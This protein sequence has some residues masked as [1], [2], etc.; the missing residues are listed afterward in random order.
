ME[1]TNNTL[2]KATKRCPYCGEEIKATAKKCRHCGEWLEEE[3]QPPTVNEEP[4]AGDSEAVEEEEANQIAPPWSSGW[5]TL[6]FVLAV[7]GELL[8]LVQEDWVSISVTDTHLISKTG[9]FG[10]IDGIFK[11]LQ[12]VPYEL[13]SIISIVGELGLL[14]M[15][16]R[17]MKNLV[18]P[19]TSLF[20]SF[21]GL[22]AFTSVFIFIVIASGTEE[23]GIW[24]LALLLMAATSVLQ[25]VLGY[26]IRAAYEPPLGF[27]GLL[28]I[29]IGAF[30]VFYLAIN[31]FSENPFGL[32]PIITSCVSTL[33]YIYLYFKLGYLLGMSERI[34][35]E[36]Q[37]VVYLFIVG[38]FVYGMMT[39]NKYGDLDLSDVDT[40]TV[41]ETEDEN[42]ED[43]GGSSSGESITVSLSGQVGYVNNIWV[44]DL[45]ISDDGDVV[46]TSYPLS[47]FDNTY[48]VTGTFD[49]ENLVLEAVSADKYTYEGSFDGET[50]KGDYVYE[51]GTDGDAGTFELTV[52]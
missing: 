28:F 49:G 46:G 37:Y 30:D 27:I 26:K 48:D 25:I 36:T 35:V 16:F 50:Y 43:T 17:G 3:P 51:A 29:I 31:A 33:L 45:E 44:M 8:L 9:K 34:R 18:Q 32:F 39:Y 20:G 1:E 40:E 21:L 13:C 10:F 22:C 42:G 4:E 23:V 38:V 15:L 5:I 14:Y 11:S 41:D 6:L 12:E 52:D 47:N 7:V 24:L 2:V 19:F